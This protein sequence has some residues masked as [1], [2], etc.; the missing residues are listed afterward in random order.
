M[1][2]ERLG[3]VWRRAMMLDLAQP[4]QQL[5]KLGHNFLLAGPIKGKIFAPLS[6]LHVF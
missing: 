1:E 3:G 2:L 4:E 6:P 5:L